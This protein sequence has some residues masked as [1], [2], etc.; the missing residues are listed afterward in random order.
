VND[1]GERLELDRRE[2]GCENGILNPFVTTERTQDSSV[3]LFHARWNKWSRPPTGGSPAVSACRGMTG[4]GETPSDGGQ[5]GV[6]RSRLD[7]EYLISHFQICGDGN[8]L[9]PSVGAKFHAGRFVTR[10]C[11]G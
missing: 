4:L 10:I 2:G 1:S 3:N 6:W 8:A 7:K 11:Q 5:S 9:F